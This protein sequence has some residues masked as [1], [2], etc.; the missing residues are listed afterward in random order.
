MATK[1]AEPAPE[2]TE[3]PEEPEAKDDLT[4]KIR[5]VVKEV[6]GEATPAKDEPVEDEKILSPREEERRTNSIVS[7]IIQGFKEALGEAKAEAKEEKKE[8]ET[9]PASKPVRRIEKILWGKE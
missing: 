6:L 2:E 4:A 1:K 7:D 8:P 5:E 9:V 3:T